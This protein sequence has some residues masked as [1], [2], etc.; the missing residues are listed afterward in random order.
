[1]H[2]PRN[3]DRTS[4]KLPVAILAHPSIYTVNNAMLPYK[5][6]Y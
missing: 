1:M 3:I 6:G 4:Y 5:N 2:A